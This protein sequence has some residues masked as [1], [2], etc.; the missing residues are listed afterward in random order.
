M[1]REINM[2]DRILKPIRGYDP[3]ILRRI[4]VKLKRQKKTD[5]ESYAVGEMLH[6]AIIYLINEDLKIYD[7]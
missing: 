3:E 4:S 2:L 1:N 6:R 7:N 5:G